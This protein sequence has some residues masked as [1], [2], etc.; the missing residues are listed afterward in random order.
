[1]LREKSGSVK[2]YIKGVLGGI[3]AILAAFGWTVT[4]AFLI[5]LL[6]QKH[7]MAFGLRVDRANSPP[8][9]TALF[10]IFSIGF[11]LGFRKVYSR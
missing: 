2:R 11:Y 6:C 9:W 10:V 3:L 1:M 8:F 5:A 7:D 4:L